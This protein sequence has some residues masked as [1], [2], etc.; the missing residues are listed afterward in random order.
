MEYRWKANC[1]QPDE[2]V[3]Y[4]RSRSLAAFPGGLAIAIVKLLI[5]IRAEVAL[6][7]FFHQPLFFH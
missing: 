7:E 1:S 4:T 2:S 6:F 3:D 5:V